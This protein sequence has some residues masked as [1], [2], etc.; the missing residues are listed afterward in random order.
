MTLEKD[1]EDQSKYY[2]SYSKPSVLKL[3]NCDIHVAEWANIPK[4]STLDDIVASL[5]LLELCFVDVLADL[6]FGSTKLY[7]HREKADISFE[8]TNEN[9]HLFIKHATS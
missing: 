9:I 4:F 1:K 6:I 7:S 5:R 8:I 2:L 3:S